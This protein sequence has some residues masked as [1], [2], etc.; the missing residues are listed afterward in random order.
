M[1]YTNVDRFFDCLIDVQPVQFLLDLLNTR[2]R[3]TADVVSH[4][5]KAADDVIIHSMVLINT[6][7]CPL[8]P[9]S[10]PA[11]VLEFPFNDL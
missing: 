1:R 5:G 4:R 7:S 6:I 11:T 3:R 8:A 9:T 10:A 2:S